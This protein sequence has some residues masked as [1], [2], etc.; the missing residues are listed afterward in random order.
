MANTIRLQTGAI[1]K[2]LFLTQRKHTQRSGTAN[3]GPDTNIHRTHRNR[4]ST[5]T[6]SNLTEP[7][8]SATPIKSNQYGNIIPECPRY[9]VARYDLEHKIRDKAEKRKNARN[10]GEP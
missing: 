4:R 8:L 2:T 6:D 10:N 9:E 5:C 3:T 7:E 1:A